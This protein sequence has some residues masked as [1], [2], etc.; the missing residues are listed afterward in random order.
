[1]IADACYRQ[2]GTRKMLIKCTLNAIQLKNLLKLFSTSCLLMVVFIPATLGQES[3]DP[4]LG[5]SYEHL[6]P[7]V[8]EE[9]IVYANAHLR[10]KL[11]FILLLEDDAIW[12]LLRSIWLKDSRQWTRFHTIGAFRSIDGGNKPDQLLIRRRTP[13]FL[14]DDPLARELEFLPLNLHAK[15]VSYINLLEAIELPDGFQEVDFYVWAQQ[16]FVVLL[17]WLQDHEQW[18]PY[19]TPAMPDSL[20]SLFIGWPQIGRNNRSVALPGPEKLRVSIVSQEELRLLYR[21]ACNLPDLW[22]YGR[23]EYCAYR[24]GD[25]RNFL[26]DK[27]FLVTNVLL[28]GPRN[29]G[30]LQIP[31]QEQPGTIKKLDWH[32]STLLVVFGDNGLQ[33]APLDPRI[34]DNPITFDSWYSELTERTGK[35]PSIY[36]TDRCRPPQFYFTG[37]I[38]F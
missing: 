4:L 35:H 10:L 17:S 32:V 1:M 21:Q 19:T 14:A 36:F 11:K 7:T 8:V 2:N 9:Q 28:E 12:L 26:Q 25:I 5:L 30:Y 24:A 18:S 23:D 29:A 6:Q 13:L 3:Q 27:N 33:L 31:S 38:I 20:G 15:P 16:D 22:K 34:S 37:S